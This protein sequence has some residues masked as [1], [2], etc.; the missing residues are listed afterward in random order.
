MSYTKISTSLYERQFR[1]SLVWVWNESKKIKQTSNTKTK[2]DENLSP[3]REKY[4]MGRRYP[5]PYQKTGKE[6]DKIEKTEKF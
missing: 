2:C 1:H 5:S 4:L 3:G 6:N